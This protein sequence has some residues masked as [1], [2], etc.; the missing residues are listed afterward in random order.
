[1]IDVIYTKYD[2]EGRTIKKSP[3]TQKL[4]GGYYTPPTIANFLAH[5][6]IRHS[7]DK[8]LEP[9]CGDGNLLMAAGQVLLEH[10]TSS[11][12]LPNQIQGVEADSQE[13]IKARLRLEEFG[14]V[15]NG[16]IREG[17]FFTFCRDKILGGTL[18]TGTLNNQQEYDVVIGNPPF[19]RY[20]TFPENQRTVAFEIMRRVGMN[21]NRLT[22]AWV[23]FLVAS[24]LALGKQGRLAMVIPAELLQVSY[25]EEI[26]QFLSIHYQEIIVV[27]FRNL[28]FENVQQEIVLL[29]A[30]KGTNKNHLIRTLELEDTH[31]LTSTFPKLLFS[32][33]GHKPLVSSKDKWTQ[34]F[35]NATEI[36]FLQTLKSHPQ[37]M[38][39]GE[40]FEAS[41][42]VVTGQNDFFLMSEVQRI[43]HHIGLE[44]V[45]PIVSRSAHLSGGI[46][47]QTDWIRNQEKFLPVHL[48]YPTNVPQVELPDS[49]QIYIQDGEQQGIQ[50]GYKCRI[51]PHWYHVSSVWK[52]DAFMLRQVHK[53]PKLVLN[54]TGATCTDT[55]HRVRFRPNVDGHR[56]T[57]AFL[58]SLTFAFAEIT[59]RGY[60]GGVLTFEP[61]ESR[62]LPM[63]LANAEQLDIE[64]IDCKLRSQK[65]EEVLEINDTV[66]LQNGLG[67]N[68]K[69]VQ[70]V[71]TIWAKLRDRRIHRKS[72]RKTKTE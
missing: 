35:L 11:S 45:H 40:L 16:Q 57:G 7:T 48:F 61:S 34:Y 26:R 29:L 38:L 10:G 69:E 19:I 8:V 58:N 62:R 67:L 22:N 14:M 53:F 65:I 46:F 52:P 49:S 1:M 24:T 27:T 28:V 50:K 66:L 42:G 33:N 23:P 4:R 18:L 17:D 71:R 72:A 68:K 37:L 13:A 3:S 56:V 44:T 36:E 47:S 59:G 9:S 32:A 70:M 21:P 63:T 41:V 51:R 5:W 12:A 31:A 60:G 55:I 6:A 39:T 54:Q 64:W 25:A 43:K 2:S 20:Q 15:W 30:E